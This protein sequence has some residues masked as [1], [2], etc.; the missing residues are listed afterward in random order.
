MQDDVTKKNLKELDALVTDNL[1]LVPESAIFENALVSIA[2]DPNVTAAFP[3]LKTSLF[4]YE[5]VDSGDLIE[6]EYRLLKL[7]L[8]IHNTGCDYSSSEA[9]SLKDGAGITNL[10]GGM[11]PLIAAA[12]LIN[13]N[14]TSMDLGAGNGLQGLLLQ[15]LTPHRKTIQVELST[16]MIEAGKLLHKA[17]KIPQERVRWSA[18]DISE[19]R[20]GD[21]DFLYIYR[22][23]KPH[24]EG[25]KLYEQVAGNLASLDKNIT[26]LSVADCLGPYIKDSFSEFHS[27]EFF[28]IYRSS[29]A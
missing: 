10:P 12:R 9:D 21:L 1:F 24:G 18:E 26:V 2:S 16:K 11:Y 3:F 27:N 15:C 14:M 23:V 13:E 25:K 6:R 22:P 28:T 8:A 19:Q 5:K 17:L 7:Y 20:F 29:T 4:E